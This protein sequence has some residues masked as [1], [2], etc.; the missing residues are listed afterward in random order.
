MRLN[1]YARAPRAPPDAVGCR[2]SHGP[3]HPP[4]A[5]DLVPTA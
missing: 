5:A 4:G 1:V 3:A 2:L